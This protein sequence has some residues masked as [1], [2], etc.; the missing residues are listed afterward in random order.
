MLLREVVEEITEKLPPEVSVSPESIV[1]KVTQIRDQLL[2][3]YGPAQRQSGTLCVYI[4]L[5]EGQSLYY[6]LCP[7]D[8]V[9][10]VA[11]L[12]TAY[13]GNGEWV[14]IPHRQFDERTQKP[15]YYF[16]AGKI[17]LYPPPTH[18]AAGGMKIFYVPV[19]KPL[20]TEDMDKPTGFDPDFDM[21]L[22][23]G[24]LNDVTIEPVSNQWYEKYQTLL[25]EYISAT[26][27]YER[28]VVKERW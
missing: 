23:Y 5:H 21:L 26:N 4:D 7:P 25:S 24:V 16:V 27:G 17:G 10:E 19:L 1:R 20:T 13:G 2:R 22:V 3:N 18:F 11:I 28:Y 8:G 6:P 15:Y 9:V 12:N 14:R